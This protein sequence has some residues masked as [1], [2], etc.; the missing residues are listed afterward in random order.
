MT[1]DEKLTE[2]EKK[3]PGIKDKVKQDTVNWGGA[4]KDIYPTDAVYAENDNY[5][6]VAAKVMERSWEARSGQGIRQV[7]HVEIHYK[8]QGSD[9]LQKIE[10]DE[11]MTIDPRS[12]RYDRVDLLPYTLVDLELTGDC[13]SAVWKDKDG[14]TVNRQVFDLISGRKSQ[15]NW[16]F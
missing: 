7:E 10:G 1:V 3:L 4:H 9:K 13:A 6:V 14:K 15:E 11:V 12:A 8:V 16:L 5:Q 2:I